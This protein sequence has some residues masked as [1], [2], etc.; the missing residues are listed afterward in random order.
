[1]R[2]VVAVTHIYYLQVSSFRN[3]SQA[4]SQGALG[5]DLVCT[6][7]ANTVNG[8]PASRLL[9]DNMTKRSVKLSRW[10]ARKAKQ[11]H[12]GAFYSSKL[13]PHCQCIC[14]DLQ[15]CNVIRV[16]VL[17][18]FALTFCLCM[19]SAALRAHSQMLF[20]AL[21]TTAPNLARVVVISQAIDDW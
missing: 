17:F 12:L 9:K 15:H 20:I 3:E 11:A 8:I 19:L 18:C 2:D 21:S 6:D 14:H 1:M 10:E 13:L 7:F 4:A 16:T 5:V